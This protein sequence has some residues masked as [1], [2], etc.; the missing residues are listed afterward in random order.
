MTSTSD[1]PPHTSSSG[2]N[3]DV[4][5]PCC[6]NP[7]A[8]ATG[9]FFA[10]LCQECEDE[11]APPRGL[12][13]VNMDFDVHPKD[14]FYLYANG[15]WLKSNPIP[16]GYPNWNSFL[17]LHVQS[18]ENLKTILEE[19]SGREPGNATEEE[20]K[21]ASFF[22][23]AMDEAA[24][25]AAGIEPL[26]P[27]LEACAKIVAASGDS[28]TKGEYARGLGD[29]L[30]VSGVSPF[31]S[32]S[33]SP[34]KMNSDLSIAQL[35]QGGLGLP[36]RDYYFDADKQDKRDAY[37]KAVGRFLTLLDDPAAS[38]SEG[39][40]AN[41]ALAKKVFDLEVDLAGSH[42]TR[43]ENR[44]PHA[45]YNKMTMDGL[46]GDL[47]KDQFDFGSYFLAA[48]GK[49]SVEAVGEINV[50]NTQAIAKA[51]ELASTVDRDTLSA[52]LKWKVLSSCAPY[53]SS[54]FVTAH[55]DFFEKTL[56][57]T[58]EIKP[59]WKRAMAFTESALGEALGKLYCAKYFDESSKQ[60]ALVIVEKVRQALEDRLNEVDWIKAD[61]TRQQAL[62]KM[63]RFRVKIGYPDEWI[64]YT[65]LKFE[66]DDTF[67]GMV[68]KAREFDNSID[69]KEMNA[70][71]NRKKWVR[72]HNMGSCDY[73]GMSTKRK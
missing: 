17:T 50:R 37:V 47:G 31:F 51:V 64:D 2:N 39:T 8:A 42:M 56:M 10:R 69:S 52:Y 35:S 49:D 66:E 65:P 11:S 73:V 23:A 44:D 59:R 62:K 40:D 13:R 67:L 68:L 28:A 14:D 15:N 70:P 60:R 3:T 43:T 26:K 53:L 16:A 48:T 18:Q 9:A 36:D 29:L 41:L 1:A 55:F 46:A 22:Q 63:E 58:S 25:E 72:L 30:R 27:L 34:D 7:W 5:C 24:I 6:D 32:I 21:V 20:R 12:S 61:S 38:P 33:V 54:V 4:K 71:T 57:G 45:T 19:L